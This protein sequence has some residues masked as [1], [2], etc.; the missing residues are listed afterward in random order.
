[1]AASSTRARK[2]ARSRVSAL[3]VMAA[4]DFDYKSHYV[5][6]K[7]KIGLGYWNREI[8]ELLLI[9]TRG[10]I[11]AP[12]PG[13]QRESV[14]YDYRGDHSAKPECFLEMIETWYPTLPKIELNRRG[15][16]RDG[17]SAWGNEA[18]TEGADADLPIPGRS[19]R[20]LN[21]KPGTS[22]PHGRSIQQR[23]AA[24]R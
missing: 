20:G 8:H 6:Q 9:G 18:Q 24:R 2:A 21:I 16:P 23:D 22:R 12:A 14:I 3:L 5:W 17:W 15:A 10:K 7:D 19:E 13:T 11:M 1:M 4:W